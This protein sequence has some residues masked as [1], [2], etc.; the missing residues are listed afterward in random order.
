MH[1]YA[2]VE[3]REDVFHKGYIR[4]WAGYIKIR[5][6]EHPRADA[7]GYVFEH[8]LVVEDAIGRYLND[9]EIAHHINGIKDDNRIE[10]LK[11]MDRWQHKSLHSKQ[12]RKPIDVELARIM[13][14]RGEIMPDVANYFN[15]SE[16]GLRK[17]LQRSGYYKPLQR[18]SARHKN[19]I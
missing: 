5:K 12:A 2:V 6:P 9:N 15:V 14:D 19:K 8:V 7:R 4:T 3:K 10:N 11:I 18:G 17:M 16:S 13:L 1:T